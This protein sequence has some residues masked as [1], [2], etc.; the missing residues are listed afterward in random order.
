LQV[1]DLAANGVGR[2]QSANCFYD[3]QIAD[4]L[5]HGYGRLIYAD[6]YSYTG[7]I[8]K[9][10]PNGQGQVSYTEAYLQGAGL[11][12]GLAA[13]YAGH[14]T[15]GRHRVGAEKFITLDIPSLCGTMAVYFREQDQ[16]AI[17]MLAQ[18]PKG[19]TTLPAKALQTWEALGKYDL[20]QQI[21]NSKLYFVEAPRSEYLQKYIKS[22][23][24]DMEYSGVWRLW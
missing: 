24:E 6:Q 23:T 8:N 17:D 16:K 14:W 13:K 2:Y 12:M 18:S 9:G 5:P 20:H 15:N 21:A 3:G 11:D 7:L 1:S 4:G 19:S 22:T 10:F